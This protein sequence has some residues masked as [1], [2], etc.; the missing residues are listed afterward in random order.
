MVNHLVNV[1]LEVNCVVLSLQVKR[2]GQDN[3]V[4]SFVCSLILDRFG[5]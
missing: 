3:E 2:N 4:V 5:G 1:S